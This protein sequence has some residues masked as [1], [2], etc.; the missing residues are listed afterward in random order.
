[1]APVTAALVVQFLLIYL[2]LLELPGL[3]ALA[4]VFSFQYMFNSAL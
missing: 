1:M 4:G 3:P 2:N